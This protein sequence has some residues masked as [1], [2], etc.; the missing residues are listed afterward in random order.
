MKKRILAMFLACMM[1]LSVIAVPAFAAEEE[2]THEDVTYTSLEEGKAVPTKC[3]DESAVCSWVCNDCKA[4]GYKQVVGAHAMKTD[5]IE[6]TCTEPQ[7]VGQVCT[8]EGCDYVG[9]TEVVP[10]TTALGHDWVVDTA[11]KDY[12]AAGC[13]TAGVHPYKCSRCPATKD[14]ETVPAHGHI[15]VTVGVVDADC[16]NGAGVKSKCS[17][18]GCGETKVEEFTSEDLKEDPKG[19]T[20]VDSADNKAATC[21]TPGLKGKK[22]CKDCGKVLAKGEVIP[23]NTNHTAVVKNTLKPATCT[24]TGVGEYACSV[25]GTNLGYKV[26]PASHKWNDGVF[27]KETDMPTCGKAGTKTFT[28]TVEGCGKT[29]TE[30]VPATGKHSTKID[31]N[32]DATCTAP[33]GVKK[34]YCETCGYYSKLVEVEGSKALG[35]DLE[36]IIKGVTGGKEPTCTATGKGYK[37][38][39]RCDYTE[40]TAK[41]PI[42]LPATGHDYTGVKGAHCDATCDHAAGV[43]YKCNDCDYVKVEPYTDPSIAKPAKEHTPVD[44]TDNKAATCKTPGLKGKK[45]CKDCGK[46]LAKGEVIPVNT[47]H[48][49]VVKNTLKPATC[50]ETG[51]GEY[52]CSVCGTN[53]GYKVIPASHKW[54]DGVFAKE[55]DMPTCGKAGTKTFTCTVEGCGKTK[56]ESVPATGKHSTKIDK[57]VDATCTAPA[58]VKKDYC[59]TC[60][61]Y[62]KLVEVEGSKAL[63][64]DLETIIKGVTGGKEPTCTATGKGYK[65]CTRCDYTEG[66]AKKPITLPATGHDYTGV[67]GAHCDATCDHAAGVGYKCNNCDYVKVEPYTDPSLAKPAK[68][69]TPVDSKNNKAAT[70]MATGLKGEKVCKDCGK[71]LVKGE[72]I[73]VDPTN[74]NIYL[75]TTLKAANCIT[76]EAG[77]GEYACK[78]AN[79]KF[80]PYYASIAPKHTWKTDEKATNGSTSIYVECGVAGCSAIK[81]QKVTEDGS[82]DN[83]GKIIPSVNIAADITVTGSVLKESLKNSVL[84]TVVVSGVDAAYGDIWLEVNGTAKIMGYTVNNGV[85]TF[86]CKVNVNNIANNFSFVVKSNTYGV[87]C[88]SNAETFNFAQYDGTFTFTGAA[89]K[90]LT[91]ATAKFGGKG[92]FINE[93]VQLA[94]VATGAIEGASI[95]LKK[96]GKVFATKAIDPNNTLVKF[97]LTAEDW[98]TEFEVYIVDANGKVISDTIYYSVAEYASNKMNNNTDDKLLDAVL[99]AM[100]KAI[101]D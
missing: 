17:V 57:N 31:K 63:G 72:V 11:S 20:P 8:N 93:N 78:N 44:S 84:L 35:H 83:I 39:T 32:V 7:K 54:N 98:D 12:V 85:Y 60:G 100:M 52:A 21:K 46:V 4:T 80:E 86:I 79:C 24:E 88:A 10:G 55:T 71:Q 74:H 40:G 2:C 22:V 68:E 27:A 87:V 90:A 66:T 41:K 6:P 53:L 29:K 51:V 1:I 34:D 64:H 61:Y 58:G 23:V 82:K 16:E 56:T 45:V 99:S 67:K 50:T 14:A 26:I 76:G 38:C 81:V 59:E 65:A 49:A 15:W 91:G 94:F 77:V 28:C 96:D 89:D 92:V 13:E 97:D 3:T 18:E 33:A 43:G 69:H 73:P 62:S 48:T 36:T 42:T 25:C 95:V 101:K 19:H 75:K 37:A 9:A 30:S 5:V 70:C 47:N